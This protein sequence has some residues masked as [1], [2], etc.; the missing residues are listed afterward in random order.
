MNIPFIIRWPEKI[1]PRYDDLL[2]SVPDVYPTMLDLLGFK[3]DIPDGV[4]GESY[5]DYLLKGKGETPGSQ[6][7]FIVRHNRL[8][9]NPDK[10]PDN[11]AYDERGVRTHQYTLMINKIELDSLT[12]YLWDRINDPYQMKNLA[13]EKPLLVEKLYEEEL[14][15]WLIKTGDPWR[16]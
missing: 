5:A 10:Y 14:L 3:D 1:Q 16:Y 4:E 9:N 7:Y 12:I 2:I 13:E 8:M 6:L 11:L 15:P